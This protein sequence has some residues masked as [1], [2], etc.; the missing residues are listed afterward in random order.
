[1]KDHDISGWIGGSEVRTPGFHRST[2]P[3]FSPVGYYPLDIFSSVRLPHLCPVLSFLTS[4]QILRLAG[5]P[6][7]HSLSH[8][9][10]TVSFFCLEYNFHSKASEA[11]FLSTQPPLQCYFFSLWTQD[12]VAQQDFTEEL[13]KRNEQ[14]ST[15][16]LGGS[17]TPFTHHSSKE[18]PK[19]IK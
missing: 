15:E 17:F 1:M 18:I 7:S 11:S 10:P 3:F 14:D 16:E 13:G 2:P 12:M 5:F 6:F 19:H 8:L 9:F 4:A